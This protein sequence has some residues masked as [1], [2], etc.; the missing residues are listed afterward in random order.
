MS[1]PETR[2]LWPRPN[3]GYASN[4]ILMIYNFIQV[5]LKLRYSRVRPCL[6]QG[7]CNGNK[8]CTFGIEMFASVLNV[9][10]S[11][12]QRCDDLTKHDLPAVHWTYFVG[13]GSPIN[14]SLQSVRHQFWSG[15]ICIWTSQYLPGTK[16]IFYNIKLVF[17]KSKA[18]HI[19][20][21]ATVAER[22]VVITSYHTSR[23][24]DFG[25]AVECTKLLENCNPSHV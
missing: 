3:D 15:N 10:C 17:C 12:S 23:V 19:V 20:S 25:T 13:L 16:F 11:C 6:G 21:R 9:V 4:C 2:W 8:V 5:I 24:T 22:C 18:L 14:S 7:C 1:E